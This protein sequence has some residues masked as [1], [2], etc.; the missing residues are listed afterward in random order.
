MVLKKLKHKT[1]LF[2][3]DFHHAVM[4]EDSDEHEEETVVEVFQKGY[5]LNQKVIRPA[6]V[7]VSK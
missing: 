6:M 4:S 3:H 2:D 5:T 7:K 1:R